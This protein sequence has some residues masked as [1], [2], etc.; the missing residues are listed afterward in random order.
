MKCALEA[1]ILIW[2]PSSDVVCNLWIS[3]SVLY[4]ED[5]MDGGC[6]QDCWDHDANCSTAFTMPE[7]AICVAL[8]PR[9]ISQKFVLD[10]EPGVKVA[11]TH[12]NITWDLGHRRSGFEL[13]IA[14]NFNSPDRKKTP[15]V[16][17]YPPNF[18]TLTRLVSTST[19]KIHNFLYKLGKRLITP[20]KGVEF[21]QTA[22]RD[23]CIY[24]FIYL[25]KNWLFCHANCLLCAENMTA[26][27]RHCSTK[28]SQETV[29]GVLGS[30]PEGN[31]QHRCRSLQLWHHRNLNFLFSFAAFY[32]IPWANLIIQMRLRTVWTLVELSAPANG[33]QLHISPNSANLSGVSEVISGLHVWPSSLFLQGKKKKRFR[34][35]AMTKMIM[36]S[37]KLDKKTCFSPLKQLE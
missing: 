18:Q 1:R 37:C 15:T 21:R 13:F 30:V 36:Y 19:N 26:S 31:I 7:A 33:L 10:L 22:P 23:D 3:W 11:W 34:S 28:G 32:L 25:V 20:T 17:V 4:R 8:L 24:L 35:R 27:S 12:S 9:M 6:S 2:N 5:R 14:E 16:H 29:R